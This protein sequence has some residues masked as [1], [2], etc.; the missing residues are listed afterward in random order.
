[1]SRADT[2]KSLEIVL[3]SFLDRAVQLKESRLEVLGGLNRLDDLARA[4]QQRSGSADPIMA[5][6]IGGWFAEHRNWLHDQTLRTG[7]RNRLG[8][9]LNKIQQTIMPQAG[10]APSSQKI[11]SEIDRWRNRL[12]QPP[13]NATAPRQQVRPASPLTP[14]GHPV[15]TGNR[16]TVSE[17]KS[18]IGVAGNKPEEVVA[19]VDTPFA[20]TGRPE[21]EVEEPATKPRKVVL[22][23]GPESLDEAGVHP[24]A[25]DSIGLFGGTLEQISNIFRDLGDRPH[26]MSILDDTL[27]SATVQ[28]NR[29]A[30][31]LSALII[32]Y[33]KQNG[34]MV[35]PFVK[36]LREAERL[37]K[38]DGTDA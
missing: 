32:Y 22:R 9:I 38:A 16:S 18:D 12:E 20:M 2:L 5:D 1:M 37:Q 26:L 4:C 13:T 33:L 14:A 36:R 29:E 15:I 17:D 31:L 35:Q 30:L 21:F 8:S 25:G 23:R 27:K 11:A 10:A 24:S 19:G 7:D 28:R 34:Y 6:R 3:E